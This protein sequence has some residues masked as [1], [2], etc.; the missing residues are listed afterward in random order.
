V[1]NTAPTDLP[2]HLT[3]GIPDA[4]R[5]LA[6]LSSSDPDFDDCAAACALIYRLCHEIKG[7]DGYATWKDAATDERVRR[8]RA[9]RALAQRNDVSLGEL[10]AVLVPQ[11]AA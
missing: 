11:P 1:S 9:E 10:A 2:A 6:R 4:D 3:T 5:V 7:P 8:I